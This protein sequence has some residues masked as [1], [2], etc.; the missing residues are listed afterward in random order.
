MAL[1][2]AGEVQH[3]VGKLSTRRT[4]LLQTSPQL[5]VWTKSYN[6]TKWR[7]SKSGQF[8][9]SSLGVPGQKNHSNVGAAER[10]KKYYMGE[11]GGF[12]RVRVV[13]N[14]MNPRS[15]MACLSTKGVPECDLTNLLVGWMQ[16]RV[17]NWKLVTLLNP[18]SKLQ[19]APLPPLML[20]VGSVPWTLNIFVVWPT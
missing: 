13:V 20:R 17:S 14:L 11:G 18:I 7:E 15:P 16:I 5:E 2:R 8:R 9:D 6:F 12:P 19:H 3:T 10:H 1:M 4:S